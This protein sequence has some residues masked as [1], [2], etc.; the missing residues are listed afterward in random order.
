MKWKKK[1]RIK[2]SID[3]KSVVNTGVKDNPVIYKYF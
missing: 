2:I 1:W 3:G